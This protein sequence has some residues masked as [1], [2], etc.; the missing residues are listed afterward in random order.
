M[1]K[2]IHACKLFLLFLGINVVLF[3]LFGETTFVIRKE[4]QLLRMLVEVESSFPA[5]LRAAAEYIH[6]KAPF[7]ED[8]PYASPS[9]DER[10]STW[11]LPPHQVVVEWFI[12]SVIFI[13]TIIHGMPSHSGKLLYVNGMGIRWA[14]RT[15]QLTL[16]AVV[17]YK[18]RAWV[19][20]GEWFAVLYLLQPCHMLL[21]GYTVMV[22][23]M[24]KRWAVGLFHVLFDL[25]W[26][27]YVATTLPDTRALLERDFFGEFFLF[28]FE[29]VMLMILPV[30][31]A[32]THFNN[33]T[34]LT[35]ED[36]VYRA[37]YSLAWFGIHHI[38]VMTPVSLV[39]GIQINYQTHLPEYA[40]PW[41]G[42][43]YKSAVT[44]LSFVA[45]LLF[46][47][48][49]DPLVKKVLRKKIL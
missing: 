30:W 29:H 4:K 10:L 22:S 34:H 31:L 6:Q 45:I 43:W 24:N 19:Q 18:V 23:H 36:R 38:Q 27:T 3:E 49:V 48:V 15:C 47:F 41:F 7:L 25:Q 40:L 21:A 26:F 35:W 42:R 14:F 16:L 17:Y 11:Y 13:I 37:W 33:I 2:L 12:F 8:V 1:K 9:T 39:S 46:A 20:L 44:G 28:Y 32:R 5:L